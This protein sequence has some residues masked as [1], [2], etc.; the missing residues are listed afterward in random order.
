MVSWDDAVAFCKW[1][2]DQ[3][4]EREAGRQY[5]LPTEAQ[6]EYAARATTTTLCFGG[7]AITDFVAEDDLISCYGDPQ[8]NARNENQFGLHGLGCDQELCADEYVAGY[9]G[10]P[11][12]GSARVVDGT[13]PWATRSG[14]L[15][16]AQGCDE[17]LT[18]L[19]ACREFGHKRFGTVRPTLPL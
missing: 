9:H 11:N 5:A 19:S 12:D 6:W 2:S 14:M 16:P 1:L 8:V 3:P 7:N 18:L 4:A 13:G 15:R 10:A 17:W